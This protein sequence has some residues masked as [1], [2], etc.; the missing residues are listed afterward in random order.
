MTRQKGVQ[1]PERLR[2]YSDLKE[3][4]RQI[5]NLKRIKVMYKTLQCVL[6]FTQKTKR[7][8]NRRISRGLRQNG[9]GLERLG[10]QSRLCGLE[11]LS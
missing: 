9:R 8:R 11:Q 5:L 2:K 4:P 1:P 6:L 7:K 10:F 3:T